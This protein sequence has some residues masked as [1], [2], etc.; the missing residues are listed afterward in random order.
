MAIF[1]L[2]SQDGKISLVVRA[3]CITC[4]R[5]V[6]VDSSPSSELMLWRDPSLSKVKVIYKPE[7]MG[8]NPKGK[9]TIIRR[10][11]HGQTTASS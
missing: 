10:I 1:E 6:A 11:E 9:R 8:F 4:A 2:H 5:Q 3:A 7:Q